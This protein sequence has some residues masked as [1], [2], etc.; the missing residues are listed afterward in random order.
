MPRFEG[1]C[2]LRSS[3][4]SRGGS[5][6]GFVP[7]LVRTG[8]ATV[9]VLIAMWLLVWQAPALAGPGDLDPSFGAGGKAVTFYSTPDSQ[10]LGNGVAVQADGKILVAGVFWDD[11]GVTPLSFGLARYGTDGTL[12]S[13]FGEGGKVIT[14][15][16]PDSQASALILQPDGRIVSGGHAVI[17][18]SGWDFALARHDTDGSLDKTFG[19]GGL[20]STDL[21][22]SGDHITSMV[23]QGDG[24]IVAAGFTDGGVTGLD[25]ALARYNADGSLDATF[26]VGGTVTDDFGGED[27]VHGLVLQPDGKLV[28]AGGM[29]PVVGGV[30][31]FLA[32]YNADG[33]LDGSFGMGGKVTTMLSDPSGDG[34]IDLALQPDGKLIAAGARFLVR[35]NVDG[36]V[37]PSFGAAGEVKNG[38][39]ER[40]MWAI[41]L[42][43]D[44]MIVAAGSFDVARF[45]YVTRLHFDG[46]RDTSFGT[47]GETFTDFG[48]DD[49]AM[50]VALQSDGN[51]VA[52]GKTTTAIALARYFGGVCGNGAV[53]GDESCDDGDLLDG[54]GCDTNCTPTAC[55]NGI[56]TSGEQCDDG[57]TVNGDCCSSSCAFES[58]T[59]PCAADDNACTADR[60]NGAGS[61]EH[62][63]EPD[64]LCLVP[65]LP[66][67]AVLSIRNLE[68]VVSGDAI[69][70]KWGTG[71]AVDPLE[72]GTAPSAGAPFYELCVYDRQYPTTTQAFRAQ[73]SA[74]INCGGV[75]CWTSVTGGWKYQSRD[76]MPDG[77]VS[78]VLKGG[79]A[80]KARVQVKGR[81]TRLTLPNLPLAKNP[82]VIVQLRTSSGKCWGGEFS[83]FRRNDTLKFDARS[84]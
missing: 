54:D 1:T 9:A 20:V 68:G 55:G 18:E 83:T 31:F 14:V 60:C 5:S 45:F 19:S 21:G 11:P 69:N 53:E 72:F 29:G 81:G 30:R 27:Q 10:A 28:V 36:S 23:V 78:M 44:G 80:G 12:D 71:P 17:G 51:I 13:T 24:K 43:P 70:F 2:T 84:D 3:C 73:A 42:Q 77:L 25:A 26:G 40:R 82:S 22:S 15:I 6:R 49:E 57:N 39:I 48:G 47:N 37:D 62:L 64:P 63:S 59:T 4:T 65:A 52:V 56:V 66:G 50:A 8:L 33:S 16:G 75:A 32:R 7:R 41:A 35:Y 61:C 34:A 74:S 67:K 38:D 76:G 46:S 79:I 58:S